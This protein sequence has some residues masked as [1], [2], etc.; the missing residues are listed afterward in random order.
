MKKTA[1]NDQAEQSQAKLPRSLLIASLALLMAIIAGGAWFYRAQT[2]ALRH[3]ID[4]RL[5]GIARL[6]VDELMLWRRERLADAQTIMDN[7]FAAAA[8]AQWLDQPSPA[9][10]EQTKAWFQSLRQN[11][12]Y[13]DVL[14]ADPAGQ[15][16]F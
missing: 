5:Q 3:E 15:I 10:Q 8:L 12:H 7:P 13:T 16:L 4:A 2:N 6:K 14:L 11:Y 9:I 1:T